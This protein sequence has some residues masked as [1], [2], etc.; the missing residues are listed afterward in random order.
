MVFEFVLFMCLPFY[1]FPV[2]RI[3]LHNLG[4]PARGTNGALT[5]RGWVKMSQGDN[6]RENNDEHS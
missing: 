3:S 4:F 2:T 1:E 6:G 5:Q